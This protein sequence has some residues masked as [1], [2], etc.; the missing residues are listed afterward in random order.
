VDLL[1]L[2]RST[3]AALCLVIAAGC[4]GVD[5]VVPEYSDIYTPNEVS[6]ASTGRDFATEVRGN[7]FGGDQFAFDKVVTDALQRY[8]VGP[9]TTFTTTPD[10]SAHRLYRVVLWFNPATPVPNQALCLQTELPSQPPSERIVVQAAFCRGGGMA[11][12]ATGWL[13]GAQSPNERGFRLLM[14]DLTYSLFPPYYPARTNPC[15]PITNCQPIKVMPA[16]TATTTPGRSTGTTAVG[17]GAQSP[18]TGHGP[19]R[20]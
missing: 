17:T 2:P 13:D 20:R 19:G 11:S 7:P 14:A 18:G 15:L 9:A 1:M 5:R 12:A 4:T 8:Y 3:L 16:Q 6:Y 10:T